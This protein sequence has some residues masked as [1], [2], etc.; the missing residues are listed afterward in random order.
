MMIYY[1]S[2]NILFLYNIQK[3]QLKEHLLKKE[4]KKKQH[5]KMKEDVHILHFHHL[6]FKLWKKYVKH[7]NLKQILE[8]VK[9]N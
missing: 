4:L 2:K 7:Y 6:E 1:H 8:I 9:H 3:L 5:N